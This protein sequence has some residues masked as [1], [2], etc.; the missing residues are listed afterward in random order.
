MKL[1]VFRSARQ[2][3]ALQRETVSGSRNANTVHEPQKNSSS[4]SV[5]TL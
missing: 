4:S 1:V 3:P 5:M 2:H